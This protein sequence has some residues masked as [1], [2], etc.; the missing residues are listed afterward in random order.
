MK[1]ERV[2]PDYQAWAENLVKVFEMVDTNIAVKEALAALKQSERIGET[3]GYD[4]GFEAGF[5]E[6]R[7]KLYKQ[8]I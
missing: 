6:C 1:I 5:E 7:T 3:A 8:V 4:K 2:Y